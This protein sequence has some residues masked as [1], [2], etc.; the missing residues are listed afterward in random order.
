MCPSD[1][2]QIKWVTQKL[3]WPLDTYTICIIALVSGRMAVIWDVC[4]YNWYNSMLLSLGGDTSVANDTQLNIKVCDNIT[5]RGKRTFWDTVIQNS[6]VERW[7]CRVN[8][9]QLVNTL[10]H[11]FWFFLGRFMS[12]RA[13]NVGHNTII[14]NAMTKRGKYVCRY[15]VLNGC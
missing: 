15:M 4:G 6:V 13:F 5:E 7:C 2:V 12:K 8:M 14:V 3:N 11:L 1:S 9:L 10:M